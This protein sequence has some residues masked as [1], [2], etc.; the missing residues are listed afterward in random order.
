[1][2]DCPFCDAD[3]GRLVLESDHAV[4]VPDAFPLSNGHTLVVPRRHVESVFALG[5]EEQA[6]LW[7]LVARVRQQ[8]AAK[9]EPDGFN[10]G[11]NDGIAAGQTVSHAHVHVIPRYDGD[12]TDPRGGVRWVLADRARYWDE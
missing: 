1:V 10:I 5:P 7:A 2:N 3:Q 12:V 6:D 9:H 8:L 4:A 11:I